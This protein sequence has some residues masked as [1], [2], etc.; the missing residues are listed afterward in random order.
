MKNLPANRGQCKPDSSTHIPKIT[1]ELQTEQ[2]SRSCRF[3]P[4]T[5]AYMTVYS[6]RW[7]NEAN[8]LSSFYKDGSFFISIVMK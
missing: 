3:S 4:L 8:M 2:L 7:Y 5:E 6:N 1:P